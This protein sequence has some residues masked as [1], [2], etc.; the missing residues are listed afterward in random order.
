M[1][2]IHQGASVVAVVFSDLLEAILVTF[3]DLLARIQKVFRR[4]TEQR[5]GCSFE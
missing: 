5:R 4:C 2:R 1:V 3:L